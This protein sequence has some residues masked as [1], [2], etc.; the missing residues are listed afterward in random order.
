MQATYPRLEVLRVLDELVLGIEYSNFAN[1]GVESPRQST[2]EN[3]SVRQA[4]QADGLD[5]HDA[6]SPLASSSISCR[7]MRSYP[8]CKRQGGVFVTFDRSKSMTRHLC[9]TPCLGQRI[10]RKPSDDRGAL[11]MLGHRKSPCEI[12][13]S[14][15]SSN[16]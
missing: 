15:R 2:I 3:D 16:I 14:L 9:R 12:F 6:Y 1:V 13:A 11:T 4:N 7:V 5:V 8:I 10:P